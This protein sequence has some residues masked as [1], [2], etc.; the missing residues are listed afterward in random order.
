MKVNRFVVLLFLLTIIVCTDAFC[1]QK[2][3]YTYYNGLGFAIKKVYSLEKNTTYLN[4]ARRIK[5]GPKILD[6]FVCAQ[7]IEK[8][9]PNEINI[10]NI[11]IV[12]E[13]NPEASLQSYL[14]DLSSQG[15]K[16]KLR[17]WNGLTG[18]EYSFKQDMG[19]V[20]LPTKAFWGYKGNKFFLIQLASLSNCVSKYETLLNSIIIL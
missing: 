15:I 5:N 19:T 12:E 9:D 18:V 20:M 8:N 3:S 2:S 6:A 7:N 1:Q 16:Y 14:K 13:T 10:I 11:H 17:S 4:T